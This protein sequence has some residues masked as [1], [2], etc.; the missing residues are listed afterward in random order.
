MIL[1]V[2][3]SSD[4][5]GPSPLLHRSS[6]QQEWQTTLPSESGEEHFSEHFPAVVQSRLKVVTVP[7]LRM[8]FTM[9]QRSWPDEQLTILLLPIDAEV[10]ISQYLRASGLS[11]RT[12][13]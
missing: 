10:D 4:A 1:D 2:P 9:V 8:V 7:S 13:R 5:L 12:Q 11:S 6:S 3:D